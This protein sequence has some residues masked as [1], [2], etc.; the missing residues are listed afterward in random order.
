MIFCADSRALF[1][2][3]SSIE[4]RIAMIATTTSSSISVNLAVVGLKR[5]YAGGV[6]ASCRAPCV[7]QGAGAGYGTV[8]RQRRGR[9]AG[10]E[11]PQK[12]EVVFP[13]FCGKTTSRFCS[14][15]PLAEHWRRRESL[16]GVCERLR[17]IGTGRD[18][19]QVA[20][21]SPPNPSLLRRAGAEERTRG[22]GSRA[23]QRDK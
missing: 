10:K 11:D 5:R 17:L 2:A 15:L 16:P 9:P 19:A 13:L 6:S 20:A 7:R 12:R 21:F 1:S 23:P 14:D 3:G 4:A 8:D 18:A 22:R